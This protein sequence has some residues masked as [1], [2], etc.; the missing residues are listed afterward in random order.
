MRPNG[1]PINAGKYRELNRN[2]KDVCKIQLIKYQ[3][4]KINKSKRERTTNFRRASLKTF[5]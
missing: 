1:Q 2:F 3:K 5:K 4:S